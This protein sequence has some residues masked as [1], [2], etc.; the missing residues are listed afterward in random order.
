M[1]LLNEIFSVK[2]KKG[3]KVIRVLGIKFTKKIPS[4]GVVNTP[5]PVHMPVLDPDNKIIVI[6]NGQEREVPIDYFQG[7]KIV[8]KGKNN[9]IKIHAPFKFINSFIHMQDDNFLEIHETSFSIGG[10]DFGL[11]K[12]AK[13][14]VGKNFS[15]GGGTLIANNVSGNT[16]IIGNDCML[17][18]QVIIRADDGHVICQKGTKKIINNSS[19]TKIGNHVWIAERVFIGKNVEIGDNCVVGACAVMTKGSSEQNVI[20][21]GVPAKIV[22]RDIDWYRVNHNSSLFKK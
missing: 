18:R 4:D 22:K 17:G 12:N 5:P 19:G 8:L 6:E 14:I 15:S 11:G 1:S 16:M 3:K 10:T 2:T 7:L 21:A 13:T 9:T 20:W